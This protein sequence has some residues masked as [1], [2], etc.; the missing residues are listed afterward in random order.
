MLRT[1]DIDLQHLKALSICHYVLGGLTALSS[2]LFLF[3]IVMGA[4]FIISPSAMSGGSGPPPPPVM[5]WL[6]VLIGS[7]A[8]VIGWTFSVLI[9]IAGR[10][11]AR[12]RHHLFCLIMA[13]VSCAVAV[14]LG[15]V[16]GVFT[17]IVL[18]R[19]SVKE[20]FQPN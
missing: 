16:L 14:P 10:F 12:R 5:G 2:S 1:T 11:L 4:V 20:L 13:G 17:L 18:L 15:T 9:I 7:A 3:Y 6:F 8:I 19:P